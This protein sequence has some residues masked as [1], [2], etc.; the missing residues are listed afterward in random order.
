MLSCPEYFVPKNQYALKSCSSITT[1]SLE[2]R[3]RTERGII[4]YHVLFQY[5]NWEPSIQNPHRGLIICHVL[6]QYH[7]W[8][9]S[10]QNPHRGLII[11]PVPENVEITVTLFRDTRQSEFEDK[12][13]TFV[14]QDV[15]ISPPPGGACCL[16]NLSN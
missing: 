11:W 8:E 12:D 13:W 2:S 16:G 5:H 1:G 4:I 10:I 6:F 7:N 9:P 15:S 14:I 3:T